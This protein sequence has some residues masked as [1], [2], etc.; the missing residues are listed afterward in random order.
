MTKIERDIFLFEL[1][2]IK[3]LRVRGGNKNLVAPVLL[4]IYN[5]FQF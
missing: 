4:H 1:L 3:L 2:D 5:I